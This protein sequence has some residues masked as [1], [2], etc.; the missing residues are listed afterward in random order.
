MRHKVITNISF[1]CICST[2]TKPEVYPYIQQQ[3]PRASITITDEQSFSVLNKDPEP[4]FSAN[5]VSKLEDPDRIYV[6]FV[7]LEDRQLAS[8]V[9]VYQ[10]QDLI[11]P[12]MITGGVSD[13]LDDLRAMFCAFEQEIRT[14]REIIRN[15]EFIQ[16]KQWYPTGTSLLVLVSLKENT[17]HLNTPSVSSDSLKVFSS[18]SEKNLLVNR[19]V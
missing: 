10:T 15:W 3:Y 13:S 17:I 14:G 19:K 7:P 12:L 18:I 11:F 16:L 5:L 9:K 1:R 2:I 4:L 6:L 8:G